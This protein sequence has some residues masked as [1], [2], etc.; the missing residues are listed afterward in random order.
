MWLF[1]LKPTPNFT[2]PMVIA[3]MDNSENRCW[4]PILVWFP[5]NLYPLKNQ[6]TH[7]SLPRIKTLDAADLSLLCWMFRKVAVETI[8]KESA[9]DTFLDLQMSR[10]EMRVRV[11]MTRRKPK[12]K[13]MMQH[14]YLSVSM[15][16]NSILLT[17]VFPLGKMFSCSWLQIRIEH[18]P[19]KS[20]KSSSKLSLTIIPLSFKREIIASTQRLSNLT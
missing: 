11:S 14:R 5:V 4:S 18:L 9:K 1:Q 2:G 17:N 3:R 19:L 16:R 6:I 8:Q 10:Y 15:I 12:I 13:G 7:K 20:T